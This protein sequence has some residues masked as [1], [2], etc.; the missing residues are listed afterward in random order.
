MRELF[1][2][3]MQQKSITKCIKFFIKKCDSFI[4]KCDDFMMNCDSTGVYKRLTLW[5]KI[6]L[7]SLN[8][9]RGIK[10]RDMFMVSNNVC[11][12]FITISLCETI[13][14]AVRLILQSKRHLIF[15]K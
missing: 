2:Y 1:Y 14:V 4:T 6:Y 13:D 5:R 15:G 7:H 8:I 12:V 3:K 10:T 9:F 11:S